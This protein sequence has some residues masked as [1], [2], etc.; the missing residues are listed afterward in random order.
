MAKSLGFDYPAEY[1][2]CDVM[3]LSEQTTHVPSLYPPRGDG[4]MDFAL[5]YTECVRPTR[6]GGLS[7]NLLEVLTMDGAGGRDFRQIAYES[8]NKHLIDSISIKVTDQ[9]GR[10]TPFG[11]GKSLTVVL[12][13]RPK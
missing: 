4:G 1:I 2:F 10:P 8:L 5:F 13:I 9:N 3:T 11:R 7:I 12:H 6:Y